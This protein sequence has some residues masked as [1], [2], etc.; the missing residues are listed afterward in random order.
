MPVDKKDTEYAA[1]LAR[2]GLTE[3][4]KVLF[5]TQ[6]N[7]ILSYID[8]INSVNTENI[9]SQSIQLLDSEAKA[10]LREDEEIPFLNNDKIISIAPEVEENM[11][12]V[13]RML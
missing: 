5:T 4:E 8:V 6:I 1:N 9:S 11:F 2:L 10:A 13:P 3:E 12:R 7:N